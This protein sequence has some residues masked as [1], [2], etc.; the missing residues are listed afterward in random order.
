MHAAVA[1]I[2][3]TSP[4]PFQRPTSRL[5]VIKGRD[6]GVLI[7]FCPKAGDSVAR[8][9]ALSTRRLLCLRL[10]LA[11]GPSNLTTSDAGLWWRAQ[12]AW[13]R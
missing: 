6:Q 7:I 10:R 13:S 5:I 9:E 11:R 4:Q 8:Y 2:Y 1:D 3:C 12:Q